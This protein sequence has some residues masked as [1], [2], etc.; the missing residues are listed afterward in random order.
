MVFAIFVANTSFQKH[1]SWN[2]GMR[3]GIKGAGRPTGGRADLALE[4]SRIA[5]P[6]KSK[7]GVSNANVPKL[8]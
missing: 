7:K 5:A 6:K 1:A 3:G 8:G 2:H 4:K